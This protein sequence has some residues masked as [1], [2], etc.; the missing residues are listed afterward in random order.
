M[1]LSKLLKHIE[2]LSSL[3]PSSLYALT[4]RVCKYLS[5]DTLDNI[6]AVIFTGKKY[7]TQ[8]SRT[9]ELI[10]LNHLLRRNLRRFGLN[11][12]KLIALITDGA[13]AGKE[14]NCFHHL[15][16]KDCALQFSYL[17]QSVWYE[18]DVLSSLRFY[19]NAGEDLQ[20]SS[21]SCLNWYIFM[22]YLKED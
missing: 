4:G 2:I 15:G 18:L 11:V 21:C 16:E 12:E 9:H 10:E 1:S 22:G 8:L 17:F 13:P 7:F 5:L 20:H 6:L 19:G 14:E 3:K